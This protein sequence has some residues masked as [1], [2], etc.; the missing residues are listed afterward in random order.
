MIGG[1]TQRRQRHQF[2][3]IRLPLWRNGGM[4]PEKRECMS[5]GHFFTWFFPPD[6][7][8]SRSRNQWCFETCMFQVL[9]LHSR[10]P[11]RC[12][13]TLGPSWSQGLD[14]KVQAL[15]TKLLDSCM[16]TH[17]TAAHL[18]FEDPRE[19]N[20]LSDA[21]HPFSRPRYYF[22]IYLPSCWLKFSQ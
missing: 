15:L 12:K 9:V 19:D 10:D 17:C 8:G 3:G 6:D 5:S 16:T 11:E 22:C 14:L 1:V 13:L 21:G 7:T 2:A 20:H 4:S 18:H